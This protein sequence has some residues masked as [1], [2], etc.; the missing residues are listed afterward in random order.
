[1]SGGNY[2]GTIYADFTTVRATHK[3]DCATPKKGYN[4]YVKV[5]LTFLRERERKLSTT[6][7]N[8]LH[9]TLLVDKTDK[10]PENTL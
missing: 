10:T 8:C 6:T 4:K 1:M 3:S 2:V 9:V 5:L 7:T